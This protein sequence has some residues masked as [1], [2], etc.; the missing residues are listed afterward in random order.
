MNTRKRIAMIA[1]DNRKHDL[2]DSRRPEPQQR[3]DS[4]RASNTA[5]GAGAPSSFLIR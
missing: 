2:L 1:H 5:V 4:N 3:A